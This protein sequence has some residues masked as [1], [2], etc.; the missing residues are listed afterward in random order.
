[1]HH[2]GTGKTATAIAAMRGMFD[3]TLS[4]VISKGVFQLIQKDQIAAARKVINSLPLS[5]S[6]QSIEKIR[7][8]LAPPTTKLS[9]IQGVDRQRDY[10]W[11]K[12]HAEEYCG[13]WVA[14]DEGRLVASALLPL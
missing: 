1:V 5:Y 2:H 10:L 4:Q 14:L 3:Q 9:L 11:L 12:D 8:I 7:K 6:N 13:Q